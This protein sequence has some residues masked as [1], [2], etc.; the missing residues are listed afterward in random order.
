[1]RT[2]KGTF[3]FQPAAYIQDTRS[4]SLD[5]RGAWADLLCAMWVNPERGRITKTVAEYARFFGCSQ[6][7]TERVLGEIV[8]QGVGDCY[9]SKNGTSRNMSQ[10]N[11][12]RNTV[13]IQI[14]KLLHSEF[15]HAKITIENRK[16]L[17]DDRARKANAL[18]QKERRGKMSQANHDRS[19]KTIINSLKNKRG[20]SDHGDPSLLM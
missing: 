1:M 14:I 9:V 16:M 20:S 4:L 10:I 13:N 12:D 17:R 11:H 2:P 3:N 15:R 7:Q 5:A 19:T 18:R 8:G 6:A